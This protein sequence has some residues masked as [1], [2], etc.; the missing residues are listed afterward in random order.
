[1]IRAA[2]PMVAA[3]LLAGC[4]SPVVTRTEAIAPALQAAPAS[5]ALAQVPDDIAPEHAQARDMIVAGLR[6]RGWRDEAEP[7]YL[8][9]VTLADRPASTVLLA[10]DDAGRSGAVI[11]PAATRANNQGCARRDH[12]LAITLTERTSGVVAYSGSASEFHCKAKLSDSLPHLVSAALDGM[13]G[14]PG[15]RQQERDGLR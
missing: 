2:L 6:Q 4:A 12:R 3:A 5:F 13:S 15:S 8:L 7:E 1:M 11:A 14:Q 10:G 9:A